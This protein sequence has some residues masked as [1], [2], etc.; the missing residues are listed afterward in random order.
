MLLNFCQ[1][2]S[3]LF[4]GALLKVIVSDDLP[5]QGFGFYLGLLN[6]FIKA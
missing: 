6:R 2:Y 5:A 3:V 4:I 1:H